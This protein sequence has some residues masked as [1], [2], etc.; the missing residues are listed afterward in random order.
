VKSAA[1]NIGSATAYDAIFVAGLSARLVRTIGTRAPGDDAGGARYPHEF[2]GGQRGRIALASA[3]A[4]S[5]ELIVLDEPVSALDVSRTA[6]RSCTS[7]GSW[8]RPTPTRSSGT[9]F[10]PIP[11]RSSRPPCRPIP[12]RRIDPPSGCHFDPRCPFA[13]EQCSRVEPALKT[14]A[15]GDD[16]SC[17]LY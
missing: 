14:V 8:S 11:R 13:M 2:S 17:H 15:P 7:G 5:P 10:I 1:L 4:A 9:R 6:R 16:I 12:T 3:L